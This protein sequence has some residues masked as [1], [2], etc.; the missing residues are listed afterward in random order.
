MFMCV[1]MAST[2]EELRSVSSK[3]PWKEGG[4]IDHYIEVEDYEEE[5]DARVGIKMKETE[6]ECVLEVETLKTEETGWRIGP[7][8][9]IWGLVGYIKG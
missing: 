2:V 5:E 6:E 7:F 8:Q 4:K 9:L 3:L 1:Y